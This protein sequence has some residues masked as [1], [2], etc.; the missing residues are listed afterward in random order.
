[1][2]P[3]DGPEW[4]YCQEPGCTDAAIPCYGEGNGYPNEPDAFL[5]PDHAGEHDYCH[6]C[7]HVGG[8]VWSEDLPEGWSG[9]CRTCIANWADTQDTERYHGHLWDTGR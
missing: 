2:E 7:G 1:M 9:A 3:D 4:G 6:G 8:L 5:C